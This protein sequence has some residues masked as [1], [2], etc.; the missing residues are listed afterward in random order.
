MTR[1]E[2][3]TLS[4]GGGGGGGGG[5]GTAFAGG[6]VP[7]GGGIGGGMSPGVTQADRSKNKNSSALA[8]GDMPL[9]LQPPGNGVSGRDVSPPSIAPPAGS[10][11]CELMWMSVYTTRPHWFSGAAAMGVLK[12]MYCTVSG[13]SR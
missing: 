7:G 4:A 5:G 13:S 9:L 11:T 6:G 10:G 12:V 8:C 2:R 1:P 3:A